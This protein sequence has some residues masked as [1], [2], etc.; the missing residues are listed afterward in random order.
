MV[1]YLGNGYIMMI[2]NVILAV[3][4]PFATCNN[5]YLGKMCFPLILSFLFLVILVF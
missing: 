1:S 2:R 5:Y 4:H 3:S